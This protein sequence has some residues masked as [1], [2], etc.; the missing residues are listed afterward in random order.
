M[1]P[2]SGHPYFPML[3]LTKYPIRIIFF[4]FPYMKLP[5]VRNT[6]RRYCISITIPAS[7]SLNFFFFSFPIIF[8]LLHRTFLGWGSQLGHYLFQPIKRL[9]NI[10]FPSILSLF[11]PFHPLTLRHISFLH[12]HTLLKQIH[13]LWQVFFVHRLNMYPFHFPSCILCRAI[14]W[15]KVLW[16]DNQEYFTSRKYWPGRSSAHHTDG[17]ALTSWSAQSSLK[18][19][20]ATSLMCWTH[21]IL[22]IASLNDLGGPCSYAFCPVLLYWQPKQ[23]RMIATDSI[24]FLHAIFWSFFLKDSISTFA[25]CWGEPKNTFSSLKKPL[26]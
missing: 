13:P 19:L 10:L 11:K 2:S 26:T 1:K 24:D 18:L 23:K 8:T 17:L 5:C 15:W 14:P 6:L 25:K 20:L 7:T 12:R 22:S 4:S 9:W 16:T 3:K 21:S